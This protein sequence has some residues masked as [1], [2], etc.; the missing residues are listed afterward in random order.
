MIDYV[1]Y[2]N[3]NTTVIEKKTSLSGDMTTNGSLEVQGRIKGNVTVM[4]LL[5]IY[6]RIDGNADVFD[7]IVRQN[8]TISGDVDV[9]SECFVDKNGVIGGNVICHNIEVYGEVKNNIDAIGNIIIRKGGVVYGDV[10]CG[11]LVVDEGGRLLGDSR[12]RIDFR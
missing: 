4:G 2:K 10:I 7:L 1:D 12:I 11:N 5:S 3:A 8:A 9:T 6:G